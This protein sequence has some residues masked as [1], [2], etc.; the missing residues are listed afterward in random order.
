M[1]NGQRCAVLAGCLA[2]SVLFWAGCEEAPARKTAQKPAAEQALP[3]QLSGNPVSDATEAL[4][5]GD[6][7]FRSVRDEHGSAVVPGASKL[8]AQEYG[9]DYNYT[10]IYSAER[11]VVAT[12]KSS[13]LDKM[14]YY[15]ASYNTVVL[16]YMKDHPQSR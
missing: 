10:L 15:A 13:V 5:L 1:R 16:N 6:Y 7:R 11:G 9:Y 12:Q 3:P 8:K 14:Y 2:M 4:R